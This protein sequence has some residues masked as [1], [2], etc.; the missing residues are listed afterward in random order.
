MR[1]RQIGGTVACHDRLTV[2]CEVSR[3]HGRIR[4]PVLG[5]AGGIGSGKSSVARILASL[6]AAVIDFDRLAHEVLDGPEVVSDLRRWWGEA[7]VRSDGSVDRRAVA[8]IVFADPAELRRLEGILYPRLWVRRDELLARFAGDD[9][10]LA[11]VLDAPK[12]YEANLDRL[13]D[14][15]IFVDADADVRSTRLAATRGWSEAERLRREKLLNPLDVKRSSADYVVKN[16]SDLGALQSEVQR[17]FATVLT[18]I[19]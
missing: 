1:R 18:S 19:G 9:G 10:V 3:V 17:V 6:G 13:C 5:L 14:A 11:V 2:P 12:L 15:V 7:I 4:K 8:D 16:N